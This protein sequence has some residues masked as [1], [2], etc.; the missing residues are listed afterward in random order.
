MKGLVGPRLAGDAVEPQ[1]LAAQRA[2]VAR[3]GA[4]GGVA[5]ADEERAAAGDEQPAAAVA[6]AGRRQPGQQR[7]A[8]GWRAAR[9]VSRVQALTRTSWPPPPC[10]SRCR[11]RSGGSWRSSGRPPG[12]S[13]RS[14]PEVQ[15]RSVGNATVRRAPPRC[16]RVSRAGSRSVTS[17]DPLGS[18]LTSHGWL[19][20]ATRVVTRS[21]RARPGG[22]GRVAGDAVGRSAFGAAVARAGRRAAT[23]ERRARTAVVRRARRMAVTLR[24]AAGVRPHLDR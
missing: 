6:T 21:A 19:R 13:G 18:S 2:Q 10:A 20:P 24:P 17:S 23:G 11:C 15:I 1:G 12:P 5:G 7:S 14:R 9:R 4:D 16:C 3:V 8:S 22:A